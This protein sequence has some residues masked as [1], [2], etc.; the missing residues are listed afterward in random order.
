M[1][2]KRIVAQKL[3]TG[4]FFLEN[5]APLLTPPSGALARPHKTLANHPIVNRSRHRGRGK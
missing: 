1:I 2:H 4:A 5:A 3:Q